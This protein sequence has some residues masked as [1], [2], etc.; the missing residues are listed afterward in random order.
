M[1]D[2]TQTDDEE[3]EDV[4]VTKNERVKTDSTICAKVKRGEAT[5]DQDTLKI[6]G[7]G[8]TM[9]EAAEDFEQGLQEAEEREWASRL[10]DLQAETEDDEE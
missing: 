10:R 3:T 8:E 6:K 4:E 1:A 7:R 9:E 2:D 5:R